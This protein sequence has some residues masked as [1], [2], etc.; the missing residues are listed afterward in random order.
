MKTEAIPR[1]PT[2]GHEQQDMGRQSARHL[3]TFY[4][5]KTFFSSLF[6]RRQSVTKVALLLL[7]F[8]LLA[9]VFLP[10]LIA[11]PVNAAI[12][13]SNPLEV[14]LV[15]LIR[16]SPPLLIA[17][18][19]VIILLVTSRVEP[20]TAKTMLVR[21]GSV[22]VLGGIVFSVWHLGSWHGATDVIQEGGLGMPVRFDSWVAVD[23]LVSSW[24]NG[25]FVSCL[26]V[27]GWAYLGY[28]VQKRGSR[29]HC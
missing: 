19:S 24:W 16:T 29:H 20:T 7:L 27:G 15:R 22:C 26:I 2:R 10:S 21:L 12:A 25:V 9:L 1:I 4:S 13:A 6:I 11:S 14:L 18:M 8:H 28:F 17:T 5:M 23:R 3:L